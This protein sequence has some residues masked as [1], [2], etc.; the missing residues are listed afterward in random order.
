MAFSVLTTNGMNRRKIEDIETHGLYR[1]QAGNHIVE[2][3]VSLR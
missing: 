1:R 2:G 3:A